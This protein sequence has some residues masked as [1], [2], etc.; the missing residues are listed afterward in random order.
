M[1]LS[2]P[3]VSD[4]RVYAEAKTLSENGYEVTIVAWDRT[5]TYP[6]VENQGRIRVRRVCAPATFGAGTRQLLPFLSFWRQAVTILSREDVDIVHCHDLDTLLPGWVAARRLKAKLIYDSHECYPAMFAS[7]GGQ[8]APRLLELMDRFFSKQADVVITVGQLLA[9]RFRKMTTTPV[10]VVGNWKNPRDYQFDLESQRALV[11]EMGATGKLIV[12]YIGSLN[13]DRVLAPMIEAAKLQPGVFFLIAGDGSQRESVAQLMENAEHGKYLGRIPLAEVPR[14]VALSDVVYYGLN[15]ND[16][17]N[18]FSAPN[19]LFAALAAGKAV[20]TTPVGEIAQIVRHHEC[21]IVLNSP[22]VKVIM[23]A[24]QQLKNQGFL[25]R[26]QQNAQDAGQT[27]Y[28]WNAAQRTL[29]E[30]YAG[31]KANADLSSAP[32]I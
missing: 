7:H 27:K 18:C 23:Q 32:T 2:N 28:N 13:Q 19:A 12:S 16:R 21:G 5:C 22:S 29:L 30:I 6:E 15:E 3:F 24:L 26:C 1:L 4:P 10:L 20:I 25:Q 9:A 8:L 14:Y 17:N 31:L 11:K